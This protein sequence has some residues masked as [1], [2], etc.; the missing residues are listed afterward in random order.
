VGPAAD[1]MHAQDD[2]PMAHRTSS[3]TRN[4]GRRVQTLGT[5]GAR[6]AHLRS[7][8]TPGAGVLDAGEDA[9]SN[10]GG[11]DENSRGRAVVDGDGSRTLLG[12]PASTGDPGKRKRAR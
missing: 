1:R 11:G 8:K 9:L 7:Q 10:D 2:D 12:T 6:R 4:G 5:S 3:P